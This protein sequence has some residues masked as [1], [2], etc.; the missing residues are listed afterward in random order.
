MVTVPTMFLILYVTVA[1]LLGVY[2]LLNTVKTRKKSWLFLGIDGKFY[3][4]SSSNQAFFVANEKG[5]WYNLSEK[6]KE[7]CRL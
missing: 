1:V 2:I 5:M 7:R 3:F 6:T 4:H